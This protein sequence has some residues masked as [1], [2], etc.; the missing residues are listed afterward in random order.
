VVDHEQEDVGRQNA[1]ETA[2]VE[3]DE[4]A[5]SVLT[6]GLLALQKDAGDEEAAE[7]EEDIDADQPRGISRLWLRKT[8]RMATARRPSSWGMRPRATVEG[9]GG[10]L[11]VCIPLMTMMPS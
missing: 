4:V 10:G 11:A 5:A 9:S 8:A 6:V 1:D 3:G 2:A 7:N